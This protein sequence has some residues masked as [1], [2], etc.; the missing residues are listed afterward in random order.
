MLLT[1]LTPKR[2]K[3]LPAPPERWRVRL[4]SATTFLTCAHRSSAPPNVPFAG[5]K[6][7]LPATAQPSWR[8]NVIGVTWIHRRRRSLRSCCWSSTRRS[9]WRCRCSRHRG[10][11]HACPTSPSCRAGSGHAGSAR[12]NRACRTSPCS[13]AGAD[14]AK[15]G[16]RTAGR[17]QTTGPTRGPTRTKDD[18]SIQNKAPPFPDYST[19]A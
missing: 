13:T 1:V 2:E 16:S 3:S 11:R 14:L 18:R 10:R 12:T 6:K 19:H 9:R 4:R 8:Q 7:L 5:Q 17:A 15:P